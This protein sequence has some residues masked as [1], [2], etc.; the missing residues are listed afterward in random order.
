MTDQQLQIAMQE[1]A[2]HLV[3]RDWFCC[4][5]CA[6]QGMLEAVLAQGTPF[7]EVL[8]VKTEVTQIVGEYFGKLARITH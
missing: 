6:R 3:R 2:E 1:L 5:E 7:A 4:I 8:D